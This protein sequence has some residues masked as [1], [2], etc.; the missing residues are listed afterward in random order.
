MCI[1]DRGNGMKINLRL[2]PRGNSRSVILEKE[3]TIESLYRK[4]EEEL[5]YTI[6]AAKVDNKIEDLNF[7]LQKD[8]D[9]E[10]L[11]MRTQAANLI[12]QNSLC[13]IYLK[14]IDDVLGNVEVDIENARCV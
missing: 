2:E 13:L 12:Y 14:A 1:R 5:P 4:Y 10:L 7:V 9:V 11:D 6:L 8:C 3:T